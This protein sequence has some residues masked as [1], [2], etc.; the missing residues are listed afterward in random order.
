MLGVTQCE[1]CPNTD[2]KKL[3]IWTLF[4][5]C[6]IDYKLNF[7]EYVKTLYS[8]ANNKLRALVRATPYVSV[9]KKILMNSYMPTYMD[10]AQP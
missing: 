2:Q 3:C 4:T 10:V 8:K 7:D 1:M 6:R 5:Q 9:E